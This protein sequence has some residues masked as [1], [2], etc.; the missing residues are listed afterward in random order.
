MLTE[1]PA[2]GPNNLSIGFSFRAEAGTDDGYQYL[3]SHN[4]FGDRSSLNIYLTPDG[5][6]RT[7]FRAEND[8]WNYRLLDI[9]TDYRDGEWHD[10]RFHVDWSS[11]RAQV[12]I[13]GQ[14]RADGDLG[15]GAFAPEGHVFLGGRSDLNSGRHFKGDLARILF[16]VGE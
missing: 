10:Y 14:L 8:D 12:Y 1:F 11:I 15:A 5:W 6:L 16:A 9:E 3:W 4:D 13:D 2:Q 7:G